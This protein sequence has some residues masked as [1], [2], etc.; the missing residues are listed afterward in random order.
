MLPSF[1]ARPPADER[2]SFYDAAAA[3][4]AAPLARLAGAL[5]DD[6]S[7]LVETWRS[8]GK[9]RAALANPESVSIPRARFNLL[10]YQRQVLERERDELR[11][12]WGTLGWGVL[13]AIGLGSLSTVYEQGKSWTWPAITLGGFVAIAAGIRVA[14][15]RKAKRLQA[16]IDAAP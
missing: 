2:D 1:E 8:R 9:I 14:N 10:A 12:G 7:K 4:F 16:R 5:D 6:P 3:Q 13:V 11:V 15:G